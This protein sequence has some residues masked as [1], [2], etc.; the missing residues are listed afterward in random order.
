MLAVLTVSV[1]S[2]VGV[3]ATRASASPQVVGQTALDTIGQRAGAMG[4]VTSM[5]AVT[6]SVG[7]AQTV[8]KASAPPAASTQPIALV[9]VH[10]KFVDELA[11]VPAKAQLPSGSVAAYTVE[12]RSGEVGL[13]YLG[14]SAPSLALLGTVERITPL[15]TAASVSKAG[16]HVRIGRHRHLL[17]KAATWGN[18]CKSD[19]TH[20]CYSVADWYM[21]AAGEEV[22]GTES[23]QKTSAMNVPGSESGYFVTNEEWLGFPS[24]PNY[25]LEIGQQGGEFKGCCAL[26]WFYAWSNGTGYH[27]RVTAAEGVWQVTANTWNNYGIQWAGSGTWCIYVGPT[28]EQKIACE[29]GFPNTSK[30]LE[31]GMEV[32]TEAKPSAAG[33]V[34]ANGTWMNGAMYTWNFASNQTQTYSGGPAPGLCISQYAPVNFP[35]NINYGTC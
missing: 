5:E 28:W 8:L 4:T 17:A 1:G 9:I 22:R 25:W 14:D 18:N 11:K 20:H 30:N 21:S 3:V 12:P 24:K 31:D 32:A 13:T 29:A 34:V 10:G 26:W 15:A 35:G 19:S 6:T 16:R 33:S 2:L 23:E 7:A 27:E